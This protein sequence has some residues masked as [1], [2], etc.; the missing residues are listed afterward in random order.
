ML[1]H[2]R[3]ALFLGIG[4][5]D[6][7]VSIE[8]Q[9][10][11]LMYVAALGS[12]ARLLCLPPDGMPPPKWYWTLPN[13]SVV[14]DSGRA[15]VN[16]ESELQIDH[17]KLQDAGN[18]SCHAENIAAKRTLTVQLVVTSEYKFSIQSFV[19]DEVQKKHLAPRKAATRV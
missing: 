18:Y 15:R 8:P 9:L 12:Q 2:I 17:V 6:P 7:E 5:F 1:S 13:G 19:P 14:S 11:H 3:L 16:E 10:D 4:N